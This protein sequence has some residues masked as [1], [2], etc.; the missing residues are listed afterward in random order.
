METKTVMAV[1]SSERVA[2]EA[3]SDLRRAGFDREISVLAKDG[4]ARGQG[5]RTEAGAEGGIS[6]GVTTG[7][8]LGGL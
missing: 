3:V 7:G 6:E 8:V 5:M 1:F 2:E 4:R